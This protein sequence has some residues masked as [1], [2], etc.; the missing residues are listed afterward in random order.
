MPAAVATFGDR[1][2]NLVKAT[3]KEPD[4]NASNSITKL[5]A[6]VTS[7]SPSQIAAHAAHQGTEVD[8]AT[9]PAAY[10][11][12]GQV[13]ETLNKEAHDEVKCDV[14]SFLPFELFDANPI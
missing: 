10:A 13:R 1:D 7:P 11:L 5:V 6:D 4:S 12:A 9:N 3:T 8:E 14:V 2:S